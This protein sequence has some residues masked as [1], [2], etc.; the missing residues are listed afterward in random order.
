M[1]LRAA[2]LHHAA[3]WEDLGLIWPKWSVFLLW[4][5]IGIGWIVVGE[6]SSNLLGMEQPRPWHYPPLIVALRILAI[7]LLGP[8][9]EEI[10]WRGLIFHLI[11]R[12]RIGAWG[13]IFFCA[14]TWAVLHFRYEWM[15][16]VMIFL[17]G[18]ILG[19]ARYRSRSVLVPAVLHS[20]NNLYSIYQSLHR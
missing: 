3:W 16:I 17:D 9:A 11:S 14:A 4:L 15:T 12:T 10:L 8:M 13:A 1:R 2:R 18:I 20:L 19:L 7:G 5:G 6:I